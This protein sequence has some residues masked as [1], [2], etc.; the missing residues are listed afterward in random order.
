MR[1]NLRADG[2][3]GIE[4]LLGQPVQTE[5]G[6]EGHA[7]GGKHKQSESNGQ[8]SCPIFVDE[9]AYAIAE[10]TQLA[11]PACILCIG[12]LY[13]L[14]YCHS[15]LLYCSRSLSQMKGL[16]QFAKFDPSF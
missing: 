16:C 11:S 3:Q 14:L 8:H 9:F 7:Y 2:V 13:L 15:L 6:E 5:V 1:W 4:D 10:S 12:R